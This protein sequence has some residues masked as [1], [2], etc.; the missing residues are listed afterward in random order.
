MYVYDHNSMISI[1]SPS[2]QLAFASDD[3]PNN[4]DKILL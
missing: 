3:Q 4:Y 1:L 2:Q